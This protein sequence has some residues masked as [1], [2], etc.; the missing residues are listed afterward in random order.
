MTTYDDISALLIDTTLSYAT[1]LLLYAGY[2]TAPPREFLTGF[3]MWEI[4][5]DMLSRGEYYG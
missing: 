4:S 3:T 2:K 1:L 5:L